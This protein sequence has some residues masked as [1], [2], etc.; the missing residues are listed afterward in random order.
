MECIERNFI[1]SKEYIHDDKPHTLAIFGDIDV[2][3]G[4]KILDSIEPVK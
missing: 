2:E 3:S 1:L 4:K